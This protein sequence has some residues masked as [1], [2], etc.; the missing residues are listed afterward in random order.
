MLNC[1]RRVTLS[2]QSDSQR[3]ATIYIR[4]TEQQCTPANLDGT[5]EFAFFQQSMTESVTSEK[6]I[7]KYRYCLLIM[8][9]C[10]V[11][12]ALLKEK[13]G[14]GDL[15][16]GIGWSHGYGLLT[17]QNCVVHLTFR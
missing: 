12:P 16:I 9:D 8:S 10:L 1:F 6:V 13:V 11:N 4:R 7:G 15:S 17:M 5:V 3:R 2:R 14:Q